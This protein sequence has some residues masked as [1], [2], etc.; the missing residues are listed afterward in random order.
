MPIPAEEPQNNG[1]KRERMHVRREGMGT[2]A[3]HLQ[4]GKLIESLHRKVLWGQLGR[5]EMSVEIARH[6]HLFKINT[7]TGR[8]KSGSDP[9]PQLQHLQAAKKGNGSSQSLKTSA[10]TLFASPSSDAW[11][12]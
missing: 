6:S 5:K 11:P 7:Y 1:T 4:S 3:D 2:L 10:H 8:I 9:E 12:H